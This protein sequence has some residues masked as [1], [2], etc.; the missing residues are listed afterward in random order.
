MKPP[1]QKKLRGFGFGFVDW[2]DSKKN[3]ST[4][5]LRFVVFLINSFSTPLI[6]STCPFE[7]C[8]G[9]SGLNKQGK[10]IYSSFGRRRR[11]HP[12]PLAA[13]GGLTLASGW[14]DG[15]VQPPG[16]WRHWG[17]YPTYY[18]T[19]WNLKKSIHRILVKRSLHQLTGKI[20]QACRNLAFFSSTR[21]AQYFEIPATMAPSCKVWPIIRSFKKQT[22]LEKNI[23]QIKW[24]T[25]QPHSCLRKSL[26]VPTFG[27][28]YWPLH[29][30]NFFSE[31]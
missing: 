4:L 3:A 25:A 21:M 2:E 14:H 28:L 13:M 6:W 10:R 29:P 23:W 26:V 30:I 27:G 12:S 22:Y 8:F 15:W 16:Q 5:L 1:S 20:V 7:W 9:P 11:F 18:I 17:D 31:I 24:W 19:G